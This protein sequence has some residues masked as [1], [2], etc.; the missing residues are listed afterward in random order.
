MYVKWQT[1]RR[2]KA[3]HSRGDLLTATLVECH[4]IDGKPRQRVI[5]YLGSVRLDFVK[6][7]MIHHLYFWDNVGEHL[8]RIGDQMDTAARRKIETKLSQRVAKPTATQR[9]KILDNL[10]RSRSL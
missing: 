3:W 4:R 8:D 1:K 5:S 10:W 6:R 2:S 9:A 7:H